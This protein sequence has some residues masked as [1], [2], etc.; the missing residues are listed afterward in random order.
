MIVAAGSE[1][2]FFGAPVAD[3]LRSL[4]H[5]SH[6]SRQ[7][8]EEGV[9]TPGGGHSY[10]RYLSVKMVGGDLAHPQRCGKTVRAPRGQGVL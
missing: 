2:A 7:R 8:V 5:G 1:P 3:R 6:R 4:H 10:L 9:L